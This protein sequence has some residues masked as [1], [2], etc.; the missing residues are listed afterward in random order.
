[1]NNSLYQNDEF[2]QE[3][4]NIEQYREREAELLKLLESYEG[5]AKSKE[6]RSLKEKVF[7]R[8]IESLERRQKAEASKSE[9]SLSTLYRL[10]GQIHQAKRFDLEARAVEWKAELDGIRKKNPSAPG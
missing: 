4:V 6:W 10:Q 3:T 7:D 9:V 1:M 8:D 5:L 2:P